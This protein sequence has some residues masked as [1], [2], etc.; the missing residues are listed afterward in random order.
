MKGPT[1]VP[2]PVLRAD[3]RR[4]RARVLEAARVAFGAEGSNVS[5][6]EIA[7]RAGVG[8]GTVY[9]HFA[10]KEALFE[11]VVVDRLAALA[12][13]ARALSNDA[14][15]GPAVFAFIERLARESAQKRDV[16]EAFAR[17]GA[18]VHLGV[19]PAV[20][21]LADALDE[22]LRRAQTGGAVRTDIGVDDLIAVASAAAFAIS[23]SRDDE[24]RIRTVLTVICDGLRPTR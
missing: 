5:L 2:E 23:Q 1:E 15:P 24:A 21:E 14:E 17:A 9:R 6:D 4:N 22:T 18:T 7:R 19:A 13:D 3:A 20:Q 12:A 16:V 11:A 8:A 10:T